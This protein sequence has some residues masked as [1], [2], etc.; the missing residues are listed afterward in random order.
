V[1]FESYQP[2]NKVCVM[3]KRDESCQLYNDTA[4]TN[5]FGSGRCESVLSW[6]IHFLHGW[7]DLFHW[8]TRI[9][10]VYNGCLKHLLTYTK[11]SFI[12]DS[13][14]TYSQAHKS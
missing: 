6:T 9:A 12:P 1:I 11:P 10:Y 8:R 3:Q 7:V 13:G 14:L 2:T 4:S 5:R